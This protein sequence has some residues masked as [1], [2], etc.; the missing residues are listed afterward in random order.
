MKI[1][2]GS[3]LFSLFIVAWNNDTFTKPV[4]HDTIATSSKDTAQKFEM[5]QYWV[6]FLKKG[7]NRTQDSISAAKIQDAH[8]RNID[9]LAA[10]GKIVMAGP[11]GYDKD[12]RGIFII[13]AKDSAEA[14]GYINTDSAIITGRLRFEL[15]PWWT[16]KGKYDFK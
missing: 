2:L 3:L 10:L 9:R 5:K 16:A 13:D 6:V 15:H 7:A 11:M 12:L 4:R 1:L 14:A 8:M